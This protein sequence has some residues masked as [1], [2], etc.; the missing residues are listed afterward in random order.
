MVMDVVEASLANR[1]ERIAMSDR[2][3]RA[4]KD[5]RDF[6]YEK[7]FFTHAWPIIWRTSDG[8]ARARPGAAGRRFK[9][10]TLSFR[11]WNIDPSRRG[12]ALR[13]KLGRRRA[14]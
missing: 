3:M 4:V 1:L 11:N 12:R 14:S 7:V 9:Y 2:F 13:R 5:L 10:L 8:P 6:L